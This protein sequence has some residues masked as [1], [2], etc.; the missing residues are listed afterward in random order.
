MGW[1]GPGWVRDRSWA[2][3]HARGEWFVVFNRLGIGKPAILGPTDEQIARLEWVRDAVD[4][5]GQVTVPLDEIDRYLNASTS[6]TYQGGRFDVS[7]IRDARNSRPRGWIRK[8]LP[9]ATVRLRY[10]GDDIAW[11]SALP[12][13]EFF[14]AHHW[15]GPGVEG[16]AALNE[17]DDYQ[18]SFTEL[19][20]P[21]RPA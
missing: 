13:F 1:P 5:S 3:V 11:A 9:G 21:G 10:A 20:I 14:D 4:P 7:M 18:E 2:H 19:P 17:I 15:L 16:D 8:D 12:G 6:C